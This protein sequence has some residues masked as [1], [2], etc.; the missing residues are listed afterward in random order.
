MTEKRYFIY[1][2]VGLWWVRD[3]TTLVEGFGDTIKEAWD[4]MLNAIAWWKA[5]ERDV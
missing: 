3:T 5:L 4:D 2:E 1:K